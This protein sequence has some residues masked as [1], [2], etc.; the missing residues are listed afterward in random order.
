MQTL[1][2]GTLH[3]SCTNVGGKARSVVLTGGP[4][5]G[6]TAILEMASRSLC[7][8]VVLVPEAASIVFGGGFPRLQNLE[9]RKAVQ[10]AIYHVQRE[11]EAIARSQDDVALILLDRG[12][13]DGVAYWPDDAPSFWSEVGSSEE[14]ALASYDAVVHLRTPSIENGYNHANA[15]RTESNTEALA[16]DRRIEAAWQ[17]HRSRFIVESQP[18]FVH[19]ALC[20]LE[21]I[22]G[23]FRGDCQ[24][25]GTRELMSNTSPSG[26]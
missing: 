13:L 20:A 6:K 14:V 8:H 24:H 9:G 15:L 25:A 23:E 10:R 17:L 3:C 7:T 4:G 21:S 18:T 1:S 22:V 2:R 26:S 19:K 5:A 16:L 12:T 11:L